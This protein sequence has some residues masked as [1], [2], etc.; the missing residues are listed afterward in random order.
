M[1]SK[2]AR[3]LYIFI[4]AA[5][6]ALRLYLKLRGIDPETG[7]Y[8]PEAGWVP[9]VYSGILGFGIVLLL[10]FG[11]LKPQKGS[12]VVSFSAPVRGFS[13][14]AGIFALLCAADAVPSQLDR[15]LDIGF[16]GSI[17]YVLLSV[18]GILLRFILLV[19]LPLVTAGLL[20]WG[21]ARLHGDSSVPRLSGWVALLPVLWQTALLL[22]TFMQYTAIRSVSDQLL[23]IVAMLLICP[24]LL[25]WARVMAGVNHRKG[26]RQLVAFGLPFSAAALSVSSGILLSWA[27]Q[28]PVEVAM[29]VP[30]AGFY[31]A[32]GAYAAALCFSIIPGRQS[33]AFPED[34]PV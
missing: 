14:L 4:A 31:F 3:T 24:F 23:T 1:T 16:G 18:L 11:L 5:S 21:S 8:L 25:A 33:P 13:A 27:Q 2:L 30:A 26:I 29:G 9:A 12:C 15:L 32:M 22:T 7:F 19:I 17:P 34:E 6:V 28:Q 20:L 10:V